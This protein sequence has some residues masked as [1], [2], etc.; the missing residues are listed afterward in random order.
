MIHHAL[1]GRSEKNR[2][3]ERLHRTQSLFH[4]YYQSEMPTELKEIDGGNQRNS[5]VLRLGETKT[6][7]KV[8]S[9]IVS[10]REEA[11]SCEKKSAGKSRGTEK[12]QEKG[13]QWMPTCGCLIVNVGREIC[14]NE[15]LA[16]PSDDILAIKDD[17]SQLTQ[18]DSLLEAR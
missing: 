5:P 7:R 12:R 10:T 15:D 9:S 18:P 16:R 13:K 3:E 17:V 8:A 2:Y 4:S 6:T 11:P 14:S 1:L